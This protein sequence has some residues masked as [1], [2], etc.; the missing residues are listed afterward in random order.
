MSV[1]KELIG[2][3]AGL[4]IGIGGSLLANVFWSQMTEEM[5]NSLKKTNQ[6]IEDRA[7]TLENQHNADI[8][9]MTRLRQELKSLESDSYLQ[10]KEQKKEAIKQKIKLADKEIDIL[11]NIPSIK[12]ALSLPES[13]WNRGYFM[14]FNEPKIFFHNKLSKNIINKESIRKSV[15]DTLPI[16]LTHTPTRCSLCVESG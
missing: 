13:V 16:R 2:A 6:L 12:I 3:A 4:A 8:S 5:N 9:Q 11:S 7:L 15:V 14:E 1:K 10:T